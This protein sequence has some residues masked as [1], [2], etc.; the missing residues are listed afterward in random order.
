MQQFSSLE[1]DSYTTSNFSAYK[2]YMILPIQFRVNNYTQKF[3]IIYLSNRFAINLYC[4]GW[5][6]LI[7]F[8][9]KHIK[10]VFFIF[11]E[12]LLTLSHSAIV[13]KS[14]LTPSCNLLG[15][16]PLENRLVSSANSTGVVY[17]QILH[18]SFI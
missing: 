15:S 1:Y 18:R 16:C 2:G 12:S 17:L 9:V 3:C 13:S 5:F 8:T 11:N 10:C 6:R 7:F 4:Q 14:L